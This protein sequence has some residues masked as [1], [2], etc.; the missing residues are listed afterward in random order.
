MELNLP[1]IEP[2]LQKQGERFLLKCLV[3]KKWVVLTPEE[4]VR[5]HFINYLS[6]YKGYSLSRMAVER[7]LQYNGLQ[8]RMDILVYDKSGNPE[9]MVECKASHIIL[10]KDTLFQISTY[11]SHFKV[12]KLCIT[13]GLKHF[14]FEK[15]GEAYKPIDGV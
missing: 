9:L 5:Q 12:P 1:K 10:G 15:Q 14:W 6:F 3:R 4:W 11:N 2:E 7:G 13:N 8:K